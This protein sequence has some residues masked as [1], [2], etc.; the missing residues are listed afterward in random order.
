MIVVH[1]KKEKVGSQSIN[2]F[3]FV[4][5]FVS[6]CFKVFQELF[7]FLGKIGM[8]CSAFMIILIFDFIIFGIVVVD[9]GIQKEG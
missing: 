6:E 4:P 9:F 3:F 1:N 2:S 7:A 8:R 5:V